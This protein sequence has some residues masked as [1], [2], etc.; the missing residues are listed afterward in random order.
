MRKC[1]PFIAVAA[2]SS[3]TSRP[4]RRPGTGKVADGRESAKMDFGKTPDGTPVELY[5]LTNG[6]ITAKVMTY[7]A[8]L[9][10]IDVPDRDGKPAD[11]VLG[12]DNL[13]GYLGR[14]PLLRRDRRPGR[15]PDRQ[16]EV[17]ARR[18]GL[19]PRRQQRPEHAPRRHQ[20]LRQGRLE[21]RGRLRPA[22]PAVKFTYLSPDGEEGYPGNLDVAVTYTVT[23]RRTSCGSTTR[24]RPTRPRRST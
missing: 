23:D 22:G 11:V 6:K 12:F 10:E 15:Q 20:G 1:I 13:E 19:H 17:H 7:G 8:I 14:P 16:G 18:Q 5:M 2:V 9:T 24:R 3:R 21:G 4:V